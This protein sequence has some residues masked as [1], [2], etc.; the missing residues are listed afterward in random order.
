MKR[1]SWAA[2][3]CL[4]SP[5]GPETARHGA[6]EELALGGDRPPQQPQIEERDDEVE[7]DEREGRRQHS[8][9]EGEGREAQLAD[10]QDQAGEQ[11][12][13]EAEAHEHRG[14]PTPLRPDGAL[15]EAA[16][17]EGEVHVARIHD[18]SADAVISG[19]GRVPDHQHRLSDRDPGLAFD[20]APPARHAQA[21]VD[22]RPRRIHGHVPGLV[23][24]QK[25]DA[26]TTLLGDAAAVAVNDLGALLDPMMQGDQRAT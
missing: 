11:G 7:G 22:F 14:S 2:T 12:A 1:S 18:P 10:R 21:P 3:S 24:A 25:G 26:E 4:R 19:Q 6:G 20:G 5:R 17:R 15:R 23:R 13:D 9:E 16:D 8:E